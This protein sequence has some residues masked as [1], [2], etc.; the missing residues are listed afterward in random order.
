M[1]SLLHFHCWIIF[2]I[3][4]SLYYL[5]YIFIIPSLYLHCIFI[6]PSLYLHYIFI[7]VFTSSLSCWHHC[8]AAISVLSLPLSPPPH[9]PYPS[10]ILHHFSPFSTFFYL[11]HQFQNYT[12]FSNISHSLLSTFSTL[13]H[14]Y[15]IITTLSL[16]LCHYSTIAPLPCSFT[17]STTTPS[18][19]NT[20]Y[21]STVTYI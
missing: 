3:S 17:L 1:S 18:T 9:I 16:L 14:H 6:I 5:Y 2:I 20:H 10:N 21:H 15:S 12:L 7:I 19:T 4:S 13:N 11:F 8:N